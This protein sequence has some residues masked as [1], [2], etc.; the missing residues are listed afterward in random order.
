MKI[1]KNKYPIFLLEELE[2]LIKQL[3]KISKDYSWL[4]SEE[5]GASLNDE[6]ETGE[7]E[8]KKEKEYELMRFGYKNNGAFLFTIDHFQLEEENKEYSALFEIYK[9]PKNDKSIGNDS[10]WLDKQQI[11]KSFE[12]WIN[13][14]VRYEK[15]KFQ[16][17]ITEQYENEIYDVIK[18][19]DKKADETSF[20]TEQQIFMLK[21]LDNAQK[22]LESESKQF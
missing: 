17:P 7:H 11:V 4:I 1:E 3:R 15:I 8:I 5:P 2:N 20:D 14:L 13:I 18:I 9:S 22:Y 21:Y 19:V 6:V 10:D 12:E 16:D